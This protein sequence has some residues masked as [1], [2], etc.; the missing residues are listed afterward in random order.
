[1]KGAYEVTVASN[2]R[3]VY[4]AVEDYDSPYGVANGIALFH[5]VT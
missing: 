1:M 5:A 2:G 4:V 3:D